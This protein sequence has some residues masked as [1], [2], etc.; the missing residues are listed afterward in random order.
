MNRNCAGVLGQFQSRDLQMPQILMRRLLEEL[1]C[2]GLFL[3]GSLSSTAP[4]ASCPYQRIGRSMSDGSCMDSL[5]CHPSTTTD[6]RPWSPAR[7]PWVTK[8]T[9]SSNIFVLNLYS[10]NIW[11]LFVSCLLRKWT[12]QVSCLL[13]KWTKQDFPSPLRQWHISPPSKHN[14]RPTKTWPNNSAY[15][16]VW[17]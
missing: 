9:I 10:H 2:P 6:I 5:S 3:P 14:P 16:P 7:D 1:L 12:K 17:T 8:D 11:S 15:Y 4:T 13:Q